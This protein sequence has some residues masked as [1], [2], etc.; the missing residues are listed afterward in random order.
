[1]IS[2][3]VPAYN[4][5]RYL[6]EALASLGD[7]DEIVVVDDAS[8]D[9]TAA[10]A[11]SFVNVR[12][13]TRADQHQRGIA[14]ARN[15][16]L[17]E[18]RG[19]ILAFIDADDRWAP[20]KLALQRPV[21]DANPDALVL[22]MVEEFVSP[23]LDEAQRARLVPKPGRLAGYLA[24]AL[25]V[26]RA[27]FDRVGPF[28]ESLAV[29]ETVAWFAKAK[30]LGIPSLVLEPLVLE[31]RLH[32]AN[33]TLTKTAVRADYVALAKAMLERKRR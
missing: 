24:G 12:L 28:D 19:D 14:A 25:L 26:R 20:G 2:V 31:R 21:L 29:G 4:A 22:G 5:E 8:S 18:A 33:Y 11:S 1:M 16:G 27:T 10:I 17:A 3:I 32:G 30:A 9:G 15:R 13:V 23:E 6:G 7:V